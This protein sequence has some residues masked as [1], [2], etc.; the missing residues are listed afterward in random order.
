MFKTFQ[1]DRWIDGQIDG[2]I[3][4]LCLAFQTY[5]RF[6]YQNQTIKE[7]QTNKSGSGETLDME[8]QKNDWDM[9]D[10]FRKKRMRDL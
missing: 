3:Y 9:K 8:Q 10:K 4:K 5:Q 6:I 2:Q 7:N 1:I